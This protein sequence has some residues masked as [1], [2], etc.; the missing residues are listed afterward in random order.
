M[1]KRGF[2]PLFFGKKRFNYINKFG[3]RA[4]AHFV[5]RKK[6]PGVPPPQGA[7]EFREPGFEAANSRLYRWRRWW[8]LMSGAKR[9]FPRQHTVQTTPSEKIS[10]RRSTSFHQFVRATYIPESRQASR[11]PRPSTRSLGYPEI[12]QRGEAVFL[13]MRIF[14]GLTSRWMMFQSWACWSAEAMSRVK[15]RARR[16]DNFM[17]SESMVSRLSPSQS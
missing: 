9:V 16:T 12:G 5:I 10:E 1:G 4:K 13:S 11:F 8:P 17:R 6:A 7:L 14:S 15:S 2:Y 3:G